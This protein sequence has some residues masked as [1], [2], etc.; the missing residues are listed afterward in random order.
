VD[1]NAKILLYCRSDRMSTIAS[2]T[3]LGLGYTNVYNLE[4]G[5]VAWEQAGLELDFK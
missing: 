4:G 5:M 2:E 3:L 1:K